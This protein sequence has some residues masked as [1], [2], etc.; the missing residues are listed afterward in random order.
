MAKKQLQ[1]LPQSEV[2]VEV[3]KTETE[4]QPEQLVLQQ[5]WVVFEEE[6]RLILQNKN[7]RL[8]P[9]NRSPK[10]YEL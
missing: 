6:H 3:E 8:L 2:Q 7:F 1:K 5:V 4:L 10:T 9:H